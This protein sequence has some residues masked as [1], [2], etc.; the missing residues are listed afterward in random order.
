MEPNKL[1]DK[2]LTSLA[3]DFE[4][5]RNGVFIE[6]ESADEFEPLRELLARLIA[7]GSLTKRANFKGGPYS[8]TPDGYN[9]YSP[10]IK[11]LRTLA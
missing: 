2:I 11:A 7:E 10:R 8:L 6:P 4:G 9:R 5:R 3:D 1:L